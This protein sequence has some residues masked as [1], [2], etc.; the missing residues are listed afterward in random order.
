[1]TLTINRSMWRHPG[2]Q[3][4]PDFM[5][6]ARGLYDLAGLVLKAHGCSDTILSRCLSPVQAALEPWEFFVPY[7]MVEW[8][9]RADG[10]SLFLSPACQDLYCLSDEGRHV[11]SRKRYQGAELEARITALLRGEGYENVEWVG[12][13]AFPPVI[14]SEVQEPA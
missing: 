14:E 10:K 13:L 1:M 7:W 12:D 6:D 11:G 8:R 5:L 4:E 3:P 2:Y 9:P